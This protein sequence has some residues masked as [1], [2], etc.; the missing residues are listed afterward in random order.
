MSSIHENGCSIHEADEF[1]EHDVLMVG[2]LHIATELVGGFGGFLAI[3]FGHGLS[4][5]G[6][7]FRENWAKSRY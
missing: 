4:G 1:A 2:G 5:H 3:V 6:V 7:D